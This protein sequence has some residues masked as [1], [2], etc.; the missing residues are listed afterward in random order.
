MSLPLVIVAAVARNGVIGEAN[1]LPWRLPSDL[2]HFRDL[3]MGCPLIMGRRTFESIGRPLPGRHCIVLTRDPAFKAPGAECAR[4][5]PEAVARAMVV[6]K[7]A[8]AGLIAVGGG[9]HVYA[10]AL[11]MAQRLEIT[12]V[13]LEPQGDTRFPRIDPGLW[14]EVRRQRPAPGRDDE[15]GFTFVTYARRDR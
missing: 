7:L 10:E 4:S 1:R 13:D 9:G 15:A 6:G 3:T 14:R 11:P 12:E 5:L 2:K 8:G